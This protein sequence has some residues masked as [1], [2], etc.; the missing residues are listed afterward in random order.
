MEDNTFFKNIWRINGIIIM[1]AGILA[2]CVLAFAGYQIISET[3]RDRNTR[4]IVNIQGESDIKEKWQLGYMS[5]IK[6]SPYVMIPL[7]SDQNYAQ[8]YY[9]KSSS[10]IRNYLFINSQTNEKHWLFNTNQYLVVDSDVLLEGDCES[11]E[12]A[13]IAILYRVVKTDTNDDKRLTNQDK[14]TIGMSLPDGKGYKDILDG[15]DVFVGHR[16]LDEK[17]LL[18]VYQKNGTGYSSNVNLS[19]FV[20]SNEEELP[21]VGL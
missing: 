20:V 12:N 4:N 7:N 21:K 9:S 3:T 14:L 6:G 19:D 13:S 11:K 18:I 8:S 17:A 2:I 1:V 16:L 10:S 15:V 5:E